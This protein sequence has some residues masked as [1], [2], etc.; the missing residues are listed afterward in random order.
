MEFLKLVDVKLNEAGYLVSTQ[1]NKPV[2][3]GAFVNA[4]NEAHLFVSIA[5]ACKD[6]KFKAD[7]VS[8]FTSIVDKV[9]KSLS[10]EAVY[11]YETAPKKPTLSI[12]DKIAAE[13]VAFAKFEGK[14]NKTAKVNKLL[15]QFE[16]IRKTE[17]V[18]EYFEE[19]AV[20]LKKLYSIDDLV[21]AAKI[22]V[23]IK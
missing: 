10:E 1:T 7:K 12:S 2:N 20:N 18:G 13:G 3:N 14:Q 5:N 9:K 22:I 4:Q 19:G 16:A 11:E 6:K 17:Q 8:V 23:D 21:T 15:I